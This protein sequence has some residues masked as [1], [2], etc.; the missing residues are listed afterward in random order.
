MTAPN[1]EPPPPTIGSQ[2]PG[3]FAHLYGVLTAQEVGDHLKCSPEAVHE[4]TVAG[5][6]IVEFR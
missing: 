3:R 4:R 5:E 2:N 1:V 6:F